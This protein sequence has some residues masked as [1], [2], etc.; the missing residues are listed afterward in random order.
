MST[1]VIT[2]ATGNAPGTSSM[3]SPGPVLGRGR[4]GF[5]GRVG[6]THRE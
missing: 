5:G 2:G 4:D 6:E 3:T 1:Y